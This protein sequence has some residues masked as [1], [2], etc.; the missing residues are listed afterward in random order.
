MDVQEHGA[1]WVA[2]L[3]AVAFILSALGAGPLFY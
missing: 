1:A 2:G 3:L